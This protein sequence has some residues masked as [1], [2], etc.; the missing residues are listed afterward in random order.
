[1][2]ADKLTA[3]QRG[4]ESGRPTDGLHLFTLAAPNPAGSHGFHALAGALGYCVGNKVAS[5]EYRNQSGFR[6]PHSKT[7]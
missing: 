5:G 7:D 3:P 6:P 1:M 4:P 2:G